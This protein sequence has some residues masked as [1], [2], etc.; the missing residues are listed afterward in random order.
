MSSAGSHPF[1]YG[2]SANNALGMGTPT[3]QQTPRSLTGQ[4]FPSRSTGNGSHVQGHVTPTSSGMPNFSQCLPNSIPPQQPSPNRYSS[5]SFGA[6]EE[7]NILMGT[8]AL[9]SQRTLTQDMKRIVG[10]GPLGGNMPSSDDSFS[11]RDRSSMFN[12]GVN[13]LAAMA[14]RTGF[15]QN[16]RGFP[17]QGLM[18]NSMQPNN[19]S[20]SPGLM[21]NNMQSYNFSTSPALDL[22]EFPSLT[23]RSSQ[24][25]SS[26]NMSHNPM[27]GR[28]PYVGMVKQPTNESNEFQIHS[29]DFPALPGS[30]T[31]E[32]NQEN[33]NKTTS[34]RCLETSKD[35]NHF[36]NDKS[37]VTQKRGIQ[38]SKD[39]RVTNIPP[40]MVTDQFGM[41]G[42]LTFIRAAESEP[43]LVSL[44]LGSDL[45]T[46]G[47]NLNTTENLYPNFSGPWAEH[48]CRPQ[49]IDYHVP[50]EYLVNQSIRDKL[51]PVKLNR[52]GEDLLFYL[53][54]MF[55]GDVLQIAAAAELYNR[56]W[57]FHKDERVWI[58]R[59]P[60]M[61]PTEK[62]VSFE[63]GMYYFFDADNWRKVA[64]EFHLDYDRLEDRPNVPPAVS[65]LAPSQAV[66]T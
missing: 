33:V 58:T 44:A 4:Q 28:P 51:A 21:N 7:R 20:S 49:D 55:S 60:G 48:P 27:A 56:D 47:L 35:S 40:G 39:G 8:R 5:Q 29:E 19:F 50:A 57:R 54:Y 63:R 31:Q 53:F 59:V 22:S 14:N 43:K 30:Q 2:Q 52:Y 18:N 1:G 24:E 12:V 46:L 65:S 41:V 3:L 6:K 32:S 37:S 11:K 66:L 61:N 16:S 34:G 25:N 9:P 62:C 13:S 15:S 64:K 36:S 42:L 45:T 17:L 23:N 10:I 26:A 38:T